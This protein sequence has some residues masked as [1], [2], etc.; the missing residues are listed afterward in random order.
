MANFAVPLSERCFAQGH[1]R[2]AQRGGHGNTA[3]IAILFSQEG[4]KVHMDLCWPGQVQEDLVYKIT[5]SR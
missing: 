2:S 3:S 5:Q 4:N 1:E